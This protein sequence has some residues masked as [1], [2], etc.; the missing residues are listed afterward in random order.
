MMA[1]LPYLAY[2]WLFGLGAY[3]IYQMLGG[4]R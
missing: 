1:A 2:A 4:R 3:R